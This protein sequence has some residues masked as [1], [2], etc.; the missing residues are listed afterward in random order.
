MNCILFILQCIVMDKLVLQQLEHAM[1]LMQ[2]TVIADAKIV[3]MNLD[4]VEVPILT[5]VNVVENL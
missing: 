1:V 3:D 4:H 2:E 5:H